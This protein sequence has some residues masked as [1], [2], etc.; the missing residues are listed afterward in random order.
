V[1]G[2][3]GAWLCFS[4]MPYTLRQYRLLGGQDE[5]SWMVQELEE[6][7]VIRPVHSPYNSPT[8]PVWKSEETW[9]MTGL[10]KVK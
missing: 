3:G 5:I 7:D 8:W 10:Q 2:S 4:W 6:V 1:T 9:R